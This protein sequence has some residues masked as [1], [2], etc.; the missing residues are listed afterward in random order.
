M[1]VLISLMVAVSIY[2]ILYIML[3]SHGPVKVRDRIS[4]YFKENNVN[5]VQEQFIREKNEEENKRK[6]ERFK[7]ASKEFSNYIAS[8]GI[9]LRANEFIYFWAGLTLVPMMVVL[10]FS[11]NIITGAALSIIGISIPPFIVSN[12]RKKREELF[13]KQLGDATV[14][15]GNSIKGG[16]TFLQSMENIAEEMQPP[17][18]NEFAKVLREIHY[19]VKQEDALNHMVERTKNKDLE[20]L[21]SA[22]MTS[23]QVGSNLSDILDTISSTIR[24]RI[25]IKNEIKTLTAQGRMSGLVIGLLPIVLILAIMVMTPSYFE[26]FFESNMGKIL[27]IISIVLEITGFALINKIVNIK[28]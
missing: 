12:A 27:I 15:M 16:F 17:I 28:M 13:N 2:L 22:V 11:G 20:L 8:S 7:I 6:K 25:R 3:S 18:S 24:D 14:I 23:A 26:G 1:E 4:K 21:I 9:K 5:D 10:L 19:G